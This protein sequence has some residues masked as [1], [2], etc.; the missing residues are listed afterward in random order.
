MPGEIREIYERISGHEE[1]I[2]SLEKYQKTQNGQLRDVNHKI[3][4]LLYLVIATLLTVV[5]GF[6]I[7]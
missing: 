6:I 7:G 3:D 5:G 1:R 2:T 4:K